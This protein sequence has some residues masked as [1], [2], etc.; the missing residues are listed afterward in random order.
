MKDR[1]DVIIV[2]GGLAGLSCA[3]QL[4]KAGLRIQLLEQAGEVGGRVRTD[5]QEGFRLDRGFQ[6][7]LTAY[8][9]CQA[10]LDYD[11]LH[12]GLFEPGAVVQLS[13]GK[14][15]S[16]SDP[17]RQPLRALP[18]VWAPIGTIKDK[19][20]VLRLRA[21][22]GSDVPDRV[23]EWTDVSAEEWLREFG[24]SSKMISRFFRPFFTGIFLD[25]SL[26][27]SAWMLGY[28]YHYFTRGYAALPRGGMRAIPDQLAARI[29]DESIRTGVQVTEVR[30]DGVTLTDGTRVSAAAVVVAVDGD[31]ARR[32]FPE[33]PKRGW[34]SAGCFYFE[35]AKSP[36]AG[37]R[38]IWLNATGHGRISQIAV[39]SD[40]ALGYAPP[41]RSLVS[42]GAVG[43]EDARTDPDLI[44]REAESYF[45]ESVRTW[46]FLK[47]YSIPQAL[48]VSTPEALA[49]LGERPAS[50]AGVHLCGDHLSVGSID[51]AMAG[52]IA[53]AAIVEKQLSSAV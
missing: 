51:A 9:R 23:P 19:W 53:T 12:L 13:G 30:A 14:R 50:F 35:A 33:L 5:E 43:D 10:L 46:R 40:I 18:T 6:V 48:P 47:G 20:H 22:L 7:M 28:T 44:R 42:V 45:G 38:S 31:A 37:R 21:L 25:R 11:A 52:G 1:L 8:P 41:G 39:P 27:T 26:A 17:F 32:W 36:L 29:G 4:K 49:A 16:V 3:V 15:C 24:F 2:G 34:Q